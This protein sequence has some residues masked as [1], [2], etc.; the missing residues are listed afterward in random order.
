MSYFSLTHDRSALAS[1]ARGVQGLLLLCRLCL[2]VRIRWRRLDQRL[3][4]SSVHYVLGL[5]HCVLGEKRFVCDTP[6]EIGN[7][8]DQGQWHGWGWRRCV[9]IDDVG[10]EDGEVR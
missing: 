4:R 2:N 9:M 8:D 3:V 5:E 7:R 10:V 1:H 6:L